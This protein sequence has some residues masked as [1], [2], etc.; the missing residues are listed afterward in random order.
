MTRFFKISIDIEN[1]DAEVTKSKHW[2]D[3]DPILKADI[4]ADMQADIE[5]L[6]DEA[7]K[8]M[9]KAWAAHKEKT[10]LSWEVKN[11]I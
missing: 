2:D 7:R 3:Y 9:R 8:D 4:L 6:Y 11:D 5:V 1:G 10:S